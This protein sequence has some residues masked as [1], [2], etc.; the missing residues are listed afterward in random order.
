MTAESG[1]GAAA[2]RVL[3]TGASRGIGR[4][5]AVALAR[6]GFDLTLN[7]RTGKAEAEAAAAQIEAL[8]G[9]A[10]TLAFDVGDREACAAAVVADIAERGAYYGAVLN[11]G[12]NADAPFPGMKPE[13]WDRVLG[14]NLDGFYNVLHPLV[15]PMVRARGGGRIVTVSSLAGIAGNRGQVNYSASKA[16]LIGATKSLALELAKRQITVNCVA[17]GWIETEMLGNADREQLAAMVPLQRLGTAEDVAAAVAFLFS[18]GA[19]YV[20]GQVVSVNGGIR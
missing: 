5:I 14:T 3:V 9:R 17:P 2:R 10:M 15:M 13:S 16:G 20:T 11:A 12:I 1:R 8:E 6:D 19:S 18:P 4:A 7:Y